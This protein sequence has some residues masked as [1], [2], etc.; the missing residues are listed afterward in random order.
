MMS[1][2][3]A[4]LLQAPAPTTP[5]PPVKTIERGQTSQQESAR[6]VLARAPAEWAA[7]WR[8]HAADRQ[9]PAV[10]F[11]KTMVAAVFLGT[12]PTA[13]YSVE[14]MR[15]R[16]ERGSLVV[17][18]VEKRPGPDQITAQMLTSPFHIVTVPAHAG[19]V[20]FEKV[21]K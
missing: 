20:R 15:T 16:D 13:G 4:A 21:E 7:L 17:E 18:Y 2:L 9:P 3:F 12:R 19:A 8:T 5:V 11:A 10:D 14:I 1:L 6:Q